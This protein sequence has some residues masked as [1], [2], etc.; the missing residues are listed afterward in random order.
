[1][2][3]IKESAKS[4]I[5]KTVDPEHIGEVNYIITNICL[6]YLDKN[7]LKYENLNALVGVLECAKLELY[8]RITAKYEDIKIKE[9]GD[10]ELYDK[11][12]T[13]NELH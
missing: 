3:Y 11:I 12:S 4:R 5:A 2:P 8:R 1:M 13:D 6:D 10:V 9:N 7:G